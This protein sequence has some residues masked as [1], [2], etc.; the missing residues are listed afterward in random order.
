MSNDYMNVNVAVRKLFWFVTPLVPFCR[1]GCARIVK[2]RKKSYFPSLVDGQ[3]SILERDDKSGF[4]TRDNGLGAIVV[5]F[6]SQHRLTLNL[7]VL[8]C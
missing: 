4:D 5:V 2:A 1:N 3:T 8:P 6:R 7:C